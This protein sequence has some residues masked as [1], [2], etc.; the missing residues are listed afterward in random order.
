[1]ETH[2]PTGPGAGTSLAVV[3]GLALWAAL[4]LLLPWRP[5]HVAGVVVLAFA[6]W[7]LLAFVTAPARARRRARRRAAAA[8]PS[9]DEIEAELRRGGDAR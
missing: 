5:A 7:L 9:L 8:L 6:L 3:A 1:M 4:M 2:R